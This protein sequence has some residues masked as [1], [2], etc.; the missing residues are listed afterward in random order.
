MGEEA[1]W[2]ALEGKLQQG[3]AWD[4]AYFEAEEKRRL[5]MFLSG[6]FESTNPFRIGDFAE[7]EI[8]GECKV[9]GLPSANAPA[10]APG[11]VGTR[12]TTW[13]WIKE[14]GERKWRTTAH[15]RKINKSSTGSPTRPSRHS[16]RLEQAALQKQRE[17]EGDK[18]KPQDQSCRTRVQNRL[19]AEAERM[20][21]TVIITDDD[22]SSMASYDSGKDIPTLAGHE[23]NRKRRRK[24]ATA[25]RKGKF[26]SQRSTQ[27]T[28]V[29]LQQRLNEFPD[30]GLTI[31]AGCL[32]CAP[33]KKKMVNLK[34][35]IVTH[36]GS[37]SHLKK[38][39]KLI[40]QTAADNLLA[41]NLTNYFKAHP[42]EQGVTLPYT[43]ILPQ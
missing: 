5:N 39:K 19:E 35:S 11:R 34:T 6:N 7:D 33:C 10:P 2:V 3:K 40:Q 22:D 9:I 36:V 4:A 43:R 13:I 14:T 15:L 24:V 8:F 38:Y 37:Q 21:N 30:S 28:Q 25:Q 12:G 27:Q 18:K 16:P 23:R 26:G 32:F 17:R 41:E 1:D 42:D 29:S 31:S 20:D